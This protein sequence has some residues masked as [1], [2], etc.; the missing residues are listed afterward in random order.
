MKVTLCTGLLLAT[1][2]LFV[3]PPATANDNG[4]KAMSPLVQKVRAA[5]AQ[6]RD[7]EVAIAN[8]YLPGP[9]VSGPNGGAMGVHFINGSL[10]GKEINA[11]TPEALIYEPGPDGRMRLVGAE[12]ITFAA[13]W[14]NEVPVLEGHLLH[15]AGAPNRYGIPAFYQI[16]VWAWRDNPDGTFADW[17]SRV[18]CDEHADLGGHN[19]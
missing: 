11:E 9:C 7:A 6:Y 16:H 5:T 14:V 4:K 15:Y 8:G 2:P 19:H 13:D 10:L 18:S 17:N 12:F 3:A 1:L